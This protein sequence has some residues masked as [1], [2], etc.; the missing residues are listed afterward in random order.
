MQTIFKEKKKNK[1]KSSVNQR[2]STFT[3]EN[4]NIKKAKWIILHKTEKNPQKIT[5]VLIVFMERII[6]LLGFLIYVQNFYG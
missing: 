4:K 3:Q 5:K 1:Q 2:K 6:S